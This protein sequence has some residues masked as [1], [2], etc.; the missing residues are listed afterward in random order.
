MKA[1]EIMKKIKLLNHFET[2][3]TMLLNFSSSSHSN[4]IMKHVIIKKSRP[5]IMIYVHDIYEKH[6]R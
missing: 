4:E 1:M 5:I 6:I 3:K 2:M